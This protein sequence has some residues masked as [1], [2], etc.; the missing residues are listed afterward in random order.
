MADL[1]GLDIY[2]LSLIEST[3]SRAGL[4][5]QEMNEKYENVKAYQNIDSVDIVA[6]G[7]SKGAAIRQLKNC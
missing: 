6:R 5:T 2:S 1:N 7:C 4:M 3:V